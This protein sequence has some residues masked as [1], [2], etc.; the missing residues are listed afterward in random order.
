MLRWLQAWLAHSS[1]IWS[2]EAMLRWCRHG[3]H[4]HQGFD[5]ECRSHASVVAG[6]ACTLHQ[7]FGVPKPCSS[8]AGMAC[9]LIK[10]LIW[11]AEAMLRWLQ[12]W[13]THSISADEDA[14][15][16]QSGKPCC[17]SSQLYYP[18]ASMASRAAGSYPAC[19]YVLADITLPRP[20]HASRRAFAPWPSMRRD[21]VCG[22]RRRGGIPPPGQ[23]SVFPTLS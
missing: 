4:T 22:W 7:G 11:S 15:I 10:D 19:S 12:A 20:D 21:R 16:L 18:P 5:L 2:A 23:G 17:S 8:G 9:T 13:L 14:W 1:R 3:L 6:M